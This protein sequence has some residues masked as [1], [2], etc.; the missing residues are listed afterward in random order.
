MTEEIAK[1]PVTI[2]IGNSALDIVDTG[3]P[4]AVA[5]IIIE[6]RDTGMGTIQLGFATIRATGDPSRSDALIS[7]RIRI[8]HGTALDLRKVLDNLLKSPVA[9]SEAH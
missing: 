6:A 7:A 1:G 2:K 9:K 5:D 8:N 4:V 3:T